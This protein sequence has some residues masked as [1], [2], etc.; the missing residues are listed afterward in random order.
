MEHQ[1]TKKKHSYPKLDL[2]PYLSVVIEHCM[3]VRFHC[4]D[5]S[6]LCPSIEYVQGVVTETWKHTSPIS[7]KHVSIC[8]VFVVWFAPNH[9]TNQI[10]GFNQEK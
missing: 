5:P 9:N 8:D 3:F 4:I 6:Q 7:S 1:E 10:Q 2:K